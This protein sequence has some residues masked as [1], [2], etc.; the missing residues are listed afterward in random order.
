MVIVLLIGTS[1]VCTCMQCV[2]VEIWLGK[3]EPAILSLLSVTHSLFLVTSSSSLIVA[4]MAFF[5]LEFPVTI[6]KSI[7][8]LWLYGCCLDSISNVPGISIKVIKHHV[9][10]FCDYAYQEMQPGR[11]L[12]VPYIYFGMQVPKICMRVSKSGE[13]RFPMTLA[14]ACMVCCTAVEHWAWIW[15]WGYVMPS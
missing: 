3:I 7:M 1:R 5:L 12:V 2:V 15:E 11:S 10:L 14:E 13:V 8:I 6:L 4:L 9:N